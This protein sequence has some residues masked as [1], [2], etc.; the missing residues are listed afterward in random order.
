MKF[1]RGFQ[2]IASPFMTAYD[3]IKYNYHVI[4]R[5]NIPAMMAAVVSISVPLIVL[6]LIFRQKIM[7]GVARGGTK[8]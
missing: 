4:G 6:F 1:H 7:A 2:Y 5:E 3:H 8:G